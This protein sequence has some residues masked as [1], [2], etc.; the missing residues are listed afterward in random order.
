MQHFYCTYGYL[1]ELIFALL[2]F[3]D[4]GVRVLARPF[5]RPKILWHVQSFK[6]VQNSIFPNEKYIFPIH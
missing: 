3:R 6:C 2:T 5:Q 4:K 1:F